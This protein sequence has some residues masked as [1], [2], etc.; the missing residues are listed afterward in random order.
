M[1]NR[2]EQI[3][4]A[5]QL[6]STGI[7]DELKKAIENQFPELKESEDEKI[8]KVLLK[9]FNERNSYRDEDETFNGVPFPSIIAYL[10]KQKEQRSI[11]DVIKNITKN[12][13]AA[14]KFLKSAGIMDDNG[15]L[16]EMYRSE[17]K[18][19]EWSEL[20]K[21]HQ[22]NIIA[23]LEFR[24]DKNLPEDTKYP[25]L[26]AWIDWLKSLGPWPKEEWSEEDER[27][28][29]SALWHIKNSCGNGGKNSG[30]FEVY[31]W[32]K[33]FHPQPK[34]EWSEGT[35][36]MLDEISD[37]LKYHGREED[38]DF[39]RHLRLQ[40]QWKPSEEQMKALEQ[41]MDRNDKLGYLLRELHDKLKNL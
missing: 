25:V 23:Y 2:E 26:D 4:L 17:Q 37:Y 9:Y 36:K 10:E 16:A 19:A 24:K 40:P 8:R 3:K 35:K 38:A 12:K 14:T 32:L 15:E 13:E 34:Q 7:D 33:S 29:K 41:A 39:I 11:E 30:E 21:L 31:N 20:D 6:I 1:D 22:H 5:E 27:M 18:P 28:W